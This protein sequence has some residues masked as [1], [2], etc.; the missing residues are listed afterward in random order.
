MRIDPAHRSLECGELGSD[1]VFEGVGVVAGNRADLDVDCAVARDDVRFGSA[2]DRSDTHC[3]VG[4]SE[5][6]AQRALE[7]QAVGQ[8]REEGPGR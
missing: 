5:V 1:L 4:D 2:V 6:V 3:R 7:G 8:V